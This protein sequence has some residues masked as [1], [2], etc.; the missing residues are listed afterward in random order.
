MDLKK[1]LFEA[2]CGAI[3]G[4]IAGPIL[5]GLLLFPPLLEW[6]SGNPLIEV[7]ETTAVFWCSAIA[8]V[9]VRLSTIRAARKGKFD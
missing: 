3:G 4:A 8:G 9:M 2:F 1:W 7:D 5:G 6:L